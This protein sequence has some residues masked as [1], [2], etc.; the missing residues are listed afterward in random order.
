MNGFV[1]MAN[2]YRTATGID[3]DEAERIARLYDFLGTCSQEDVY[4]LFDST[5]FN[6][7]A[8]G[9]MRK[10]VSRLIENGVLDEEQG[11]AIRNEYAILMEDMQAQRIMEE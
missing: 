5:A 8:K 11:R 10:A 7:I 4:D 2:A 1:V 6:D 9:Y 3:H